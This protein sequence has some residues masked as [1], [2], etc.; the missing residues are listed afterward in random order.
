MTCA[1]YNVLA[2]LM[3]HSH[4]QRVRRR[5]MVVEILNATDEARDLLNSQQDRRFEFRYCIPDLQRTHDAVSP[6]RASQLFLAPA[7]LIA[8][9][10]NHPVHLIQGRIAAFI[11]S[12][13]ERHDLLLADG[14]A[15]AS[16]GGRT[17]DDLRPGRR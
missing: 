13:V 8:K 1:I 16:L 6:I 14:R 9:Q 11:P 4:D 12:T 15:A 17:S 2:C 7:S 5:W 3:E 10:V